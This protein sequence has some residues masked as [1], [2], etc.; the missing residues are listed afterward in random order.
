MILLRLF[1]EFFKVGLFAVGGG[2]A[3]IPFLQTMG[4]VTG[5]FTNE[6]LTTMIA[7]SES[8]PGPIG[9][10]MATY[11]GFETAGVLG[12]VI[13][14]LG[15]ITPS[16]IVIIIIAG[17]LQKFRDSKTV[18]DVFYGLRPASTALVTSAGLSVALT[19][20]LEVSVRVSEV[21]EQIFY[22]NAKALLL[23]MTVFLTMKFT[24]LKK[25]H[26]IAF[27]GISALIGIVLKM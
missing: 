9:V 20:F 6:Q 14:T 3:T 21:E 7:V 5:W 26:P 22:L 19:I 23:A 10:N 11:V 12:S 8:T 24:K 2:L 25:L 13:A 4:E 27:I 16:V 17:F 1:F 15:L 18:N